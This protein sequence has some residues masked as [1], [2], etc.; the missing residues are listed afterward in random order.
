[1][2]R[3]FLGL[4]SRGAWGP[5][6][7]TAVTSSTRKH[8][9]TSRL[10][11]SGDINHC[12]NCLWCD[13]Y[14]SREQLG[15]DIFGLHH[16]DLEAP[17]YLLDELCD[18]MDRVDA[19]VLSVVA[20]VKDCRGLTS[21]GIH[22]RGYWNARRLTLTEVYDYPE[23]FSIADTPWPTK[24]LVVNTGLMLCRF[25]RTWVD[26]FPGFKTQTK[27]VTINGKKFPAVWP[28]D[29]DFSAWANA[30]GLRV[31]ATRKVITQ[32]TGPEKF[33]T[34]KPW[35]T[36]IIDEGFVGFPPEPEVQHVND[37]LASAG[38]DPGD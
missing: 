35:G 31:F 32:H 16:D 19:D 20:A 13:A 6:C 23:T 21:C 34:G 1:M 36:W 9:L 26:E 18:E 15:I 30:R 37:N 27:L 12:F 28:E 24:D 2:H 17:P 3:I 10:G 25:D 7:F 38:Y 4:P 33:G 14:N 11:T 22:T 8:G 5:G 29:W